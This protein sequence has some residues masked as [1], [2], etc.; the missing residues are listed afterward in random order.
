MKFFVEKIYFWFSELVIQVDHFRYDMY[1]K[2][3]ID[4][5]HHQIDINE[6]HDLLQKKE[7][8]L[9]KINPDRSYY[10]EHHQ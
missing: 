2:I 1:K 3:D 4:L 7:I 9:D 6:N 10:F 8:L 5:V